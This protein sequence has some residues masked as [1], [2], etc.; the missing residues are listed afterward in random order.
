VGQVQDPG[1]REFNNGSEVVAVCAGA[2]NASLLPAR[3]E[4]DRRAFMHRLPFAVAHEA[5]S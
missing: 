2:L 5:R 1:R 3:L 4:F